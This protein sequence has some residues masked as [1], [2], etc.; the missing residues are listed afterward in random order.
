MRRELVTQIE[1]ELAT[2]FIEQCSAAPPLKA[3]LSYGC[4]VPQN[5][6]TERIVVKDTENRKFQFILQLVVRA[7]P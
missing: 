3:Q 7:K 6:I 1:I 2:A 4:L 5:H